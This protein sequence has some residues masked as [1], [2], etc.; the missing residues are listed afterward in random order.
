MLDRKEVFTLRNRA[1]DLQS[2]AVAHLNARE[3]EGLAW[4]S[5]AGRSYLQSFVSKLTWTL[6]YMHCG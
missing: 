3:G 5:G 2:G 6:R 4:I 1:I